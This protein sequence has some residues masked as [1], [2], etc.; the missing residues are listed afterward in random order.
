MIAELE[1]AVELEIGGSPF[2]EV[3]LVLDRYDHAFHAGGLG[4]DEAIEGVF[5][6]EAFQ[7]V[8]GERIGAVHIHLW[9]GFAVGEVLGG[10]YGF[11]AVADIEFLHDGFHEGEGGG[12]GQADVEAAGLK[13]MDD[14][15]YAGQGGGVV[16]YL[17]NN[18]TME[19]GFG[20]GDPFLADAK[21]REPVI[22]PFAGAEAG[23]MVVLHRCKGD[24]EFEQGLHSGFLPAGFGI[25]EQTIHIEDNRVDCHR[26]QS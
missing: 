21:L 8:G 17:F 1:K 13:E 3:G 16:F 9:V 15:F 24:L 14:R 23:G 11:E 25:D 26:A 19:R 10:G 6:G 12:G 20:G 2:W 7:G 18:I 22:Q 4:G 5:E